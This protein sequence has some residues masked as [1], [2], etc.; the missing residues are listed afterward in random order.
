[1]L[2]NLSRKEIRVR[3]Q[4]LYKKSMEAP[5]S[6]DKVFGTVKELRAKM[7][8][9]YTF[10]QLADDYPKVEFPD[11]VFEG[12]TRYDDLIKI[13]SDAKY[14]KLLLDIIGTDKETALAFSALDYELATFQDKFKQEFEEKYLKDIPY[15]NYDLSKLDWDYLFKVFPSYKRD[16]LQRQKE[17]LEKDT[18]SP[19]NLDHLFDLYDDQIQAIIDRYEKESELISKRVKF[20][21]EELERT[22]DLFEKLPTLTLHELFEMEPELYELILDD[23]ERKIETVGWDPIIELTPEQQKDEDLVRRAFGLKTLPDIPA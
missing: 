16:E 18:S 22:Y 11:I 12:E 6:F 15:R 3:M 19:V 14:P 10:D 7:K 21:K 8:K 13:T 23:L 5:P 9:G 4:E 1:M 17:W 20:Y 2:T